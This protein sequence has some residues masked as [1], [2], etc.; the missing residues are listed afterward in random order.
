MEFYIVASKETIDNVFKKCKYFKQNLGMVSTIDKNGRRILNNKDGFAYYFNTLYKTT[1]YAS[2]SIGDIAFYY[3]IY[4]KDKSI[5]V[6]ISDDGLYDEFIF[7]YD[8][9][10]EQEKGINN[11]I[12]Y[13]LK[14]SETEYEVRKE[15]EKIKKET[16]KPIGSAENLTLNPGRVTYEDILA[17]KRSKNKK[18]F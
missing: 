16:P 8:K 6:Y 7:K 15:K 10:L 13:L 4:I 2:G 9:K 5:A 17:Y 11:Y 1:I 14:E 18:R 12:G 3:D